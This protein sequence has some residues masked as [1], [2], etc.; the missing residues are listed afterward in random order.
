MAE[1][2]ILVQANKRQELGK[3]AAKVRKAGFIP[4]VVYGRKMPSLAVAVESKEFYNKVLKS[5]AGRNLIFTLAVAG[6]G[7]KKELPV[8]THRLDK[9]PL[10]DQV[11][12]I[13]FMF[14]SMDE[15]LKTKVPVELIGLP[16]GV[17]DDGGVLVQGLRDVEVKCLPGNIPDKFVIDVSAL[18]IGDA[19]HVS[20]LKV[21]AKVEILVA[22]SEM[23]AQVAAPTKEEEVVA[24]P[25]TPEEV[26]AAAAAAEGA[27]VVAA[28]GQAAAPAEGKKPEA[29]A[30]KTE[31]AAAKKE[32]D[33]GP[34]E[35]AKK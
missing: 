28:E 31:A 18:R 5:D 12:H 32:P 10:T 3:K 22:L 20:D 1:Q 9:D 24:A 8:I 33:K 25:Q 15:K 13:D 21:S 14:I 6:D 29:A 34:A 35:K 11:I 17:K 4:A 26:A 30:K 23:V 27:P 7:E 2:Q 16:A 19:L